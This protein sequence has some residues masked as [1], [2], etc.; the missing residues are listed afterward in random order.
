MQ[1]KTFTAALRVGSNE[2]T[3]ARGSLAWR[4]GERGE[5]SGRR[6]SSHLR[7]MPASVSSGMMTWSRKSASSAG[8][9]T[10]SAI[11][12]LAVATTVPLAATCAPSTMTIPWASAELLGAVTPSTR[13]R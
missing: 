10:A 1:P 3:S 8:S 2:L 6:G 12:S 13:M 11:A 7:Q 5:A 9:P 4:R